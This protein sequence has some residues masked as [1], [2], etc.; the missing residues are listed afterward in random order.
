MKKQGK[1]PNECCNHQMSA[2][3]AKLINCNSIILSCLEW[4][5]WDWGMPLLW[6]SP[7]FENSRTEKC[8]PFTLPGLWSSKC[9]EVYEQLLYCRC[10]QPC[11]SWKP[12]TKRSAFL[13]LNAFRLLLQLS[14]AIGQWPWNVFEPFLAWTFAHPG[15]GCVHAKWPWNLQHWLVI[16][17][18]GML[19]RQKKNTNSVQS[20][21]LKQTPCQVSL[22]W[23]RKTWL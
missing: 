10:R 1:P 5:L 13:M 21:L 15:Y 3:A 20:R 8:G 23:H 7:S 17:M 22:F 11:N 4:G 12:V 16:S 14:R 19:K 18:P 2:V 9:L 6:S